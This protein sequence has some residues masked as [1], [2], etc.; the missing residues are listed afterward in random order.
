ML[1]VLST[2]AIWVSCECLS[3]VVFFFLFSSWQPEYCIFT[4]DSYLKRHA[5]EK[6][7][8]FLLK[9]LHSSPSIPSLFNSVALSEIALVYRLSRYLD[10]FLED[11]SFGRNEA[12]ILIL[13]TNFVSVSLSLIH[14]KLDLCL[15]PSRV[16]PRLL[17]KTESDGKSNSL[18][19]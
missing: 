18:W 1:I 12:K 10:F 11:G 4:Y 16:F 7:D 6:K 19:L 15:S 9:A 2:V 14:F 8:N 5:A 3:F 13:P 17:C